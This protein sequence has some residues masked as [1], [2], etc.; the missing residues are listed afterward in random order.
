MKIKIF[1]ILVLFFLAV[2]YWILPKTKFARRL[3]M[4]EA[5][6]YT[7]NIIGIISGVVGLLVSFGWPELILKNHYFE[8]I[9]L[10]PVF[11]YVYSSTIMKIH[12]AEEIYDEKQSFDMTRAAAVSLFFSWLAMFLLY[13]MYKENILKGLVWYPIYIFFTL[14]VFSV[15]TIMNYKRD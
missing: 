10:P 11:L 3:K 7:I 12:K 1:L 5:L 8:L 13:A 4:N 15:S 14:T 9:L 6:F 2:C